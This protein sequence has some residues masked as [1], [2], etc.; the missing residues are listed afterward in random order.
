KSLG[1]FHRQTAAAEFVFVTREF[2]ALR[3]I[4]SDE[5]IDALE[6]SAELG[7]VGIKAMAERGQAGNDEGE[8]FGIVHEAVMR[9]GAEMGRIQ[10]ASASMLDPDLNDQ[11][12]GPLAA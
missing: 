11:R 12:P 9:G 10:L 8:V 6:K 2:I 3:L 1:F 5:E 4:N 7:D